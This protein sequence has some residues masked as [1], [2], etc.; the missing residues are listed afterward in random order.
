MKYLI[1]DSDVYGFS[2]YLYGE[3]YL[4]SFRGKRFR[5]GREPLKNVFYKPKDQ[6]AKDGE[7]E[8]YL[9]ASLCDEPWCWEKKDPATLK[10]MKFEFSEEGLSLAVNWLNDELGVK[11]PENPEGNSGQA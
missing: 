8:A 4:G 9:L 1:G 10:E 11:L 6:W 5:L 7:N 3:A 2:H